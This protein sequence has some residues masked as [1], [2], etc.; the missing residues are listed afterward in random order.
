[1][2]WE[3]GF[4]GKTWLE[5]LKPSFDMGEKVCLSNQ[6]IYLA[7]LS[8]TVKSVSSE[9]LRTYSAS[10]ILIWI[11]YDSDCRQSWLSRNRKKPLSEWHVYAP[12]A[13]DSSQPITKLEGNDHGRWLG[14]KAVSY[15]SKRHHPFWIQRL[16]FLAVCLCLCSVADARVTTCPKDR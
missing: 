9:V 15:L 14:C 5:Y 10:R 12:H 3:F 11:F 13:P 4:C 8:Q 1:M 2:Q 7:S 6:G 16:L